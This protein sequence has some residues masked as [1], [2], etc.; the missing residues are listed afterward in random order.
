MVRFILIF[1]LFSSCNCYE[2]KPLIINE[3]ITKDTLIVY[4]LEGISTQGAE[5]NVSY[6]SS[7]I[8]RSEAIIY[9]ERGKAIIQYKFNQKQIKVIEKQYSYKTTFDDV[10]SD[11]DIMLVNEQTY[12]IDYDGNLIGSPIENRIDI[13][14][15]FKEKIPFEIK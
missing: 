13:F 12:Y 9:G 8:I 4:N 11:D 7:K 1:I 14:N 10:K 3:N 6:Q 15:E 2:K 5:V